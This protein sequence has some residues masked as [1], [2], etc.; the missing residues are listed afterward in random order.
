MNKNMGLSHR[1]VNSANTKGRNVRAIPD[2]NP[3]PLTPSGDSGTLGTVLAAATF[4]PMRRRT[5]EVNC[6]RG[7]GNRPGDGEFRVPRGLL[8]AV[9]CLSTGVYTGCGS[10]SRIPASL[11]ATRSGA[12]IEV[13]QSDTVFIMNN[14]EIIGDTLAGTVRAKRG[15]SGPPISLP[16][17]ATDSVRA[18]HL[19]VGKTFLA[20]TGA[21]V[22]VITVIWFSILAAGPGAT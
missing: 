6:H 10:W 11:P 2:C 3:N 17:S 13:W 12:T 18:K 8:L 16:L 7:D 15:A 20:V 19:D 22:G 14:A 1:S 5:V 21:G 9:A 4:L